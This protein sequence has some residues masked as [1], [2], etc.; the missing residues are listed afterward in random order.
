MSNRKLRNLGDGP[1]GRGR[2]SKT[3]ADYWLEA[4]LYDG[5]GASCSAPTTGSPASGRSARVRGHVRHHFAFLTLRADAVRLS[6]VRVPDGATEQFVRDYTD[7]VVP[8]LEVCGV[9]RIRLTRDRRL[10]SRA[11]SRCVFEQGA[12]GFKGGGLF[13]DADSNT[14][15]SFSMWAGADAWDELRGDPAYAE[16]MARLALSMEGVPT[17]TAYEVEALVSPSGEGDEPG[18]VE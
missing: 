17:S 2:P 5:P 16:A 6:S 7:A 10:T 14:M 3:E 15:V 13:R 11:P 12:P 9:M 8:L 1:V 18:Q 4:G